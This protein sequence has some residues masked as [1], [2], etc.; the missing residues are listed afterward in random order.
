M[1]LQEKQIRETAYNLGV[2][3]KNLSEYGVDDT[4]I[5]EYRNQQEWFLKGVPVSQMTHTARLIC[6]NKQLTKQVFGKLG[7]PCPKSLL[8]SDPSHDAAAINDFWKPD[9]LYVCKPLDGMEGN[10]VVMNIRE[11]EE[12]KRIWEIQSKQYT[13]FLLEEQISGRDIRMHVIGGESVAVCVR[14]PAFVRGNGYLSVEELIEERRK[15]IQAQN[16]M[17]HLTLDDASWELLKKQD[18]TLKSIPKND[19]KVQL[20]YIANMSHGGVAT[21]ITDVIHP[22]YLRWAKPLAE[23]LN[24]STFAIDIISPDYTKSPNEVNAVVLEV[25]GEADW[26]HHTFSERRTHDIPQ[27]MINNLFGL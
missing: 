24:L 10:G 4:I 14:E 13:K 3:V 6:M 23:H 5:L 21:D 27:M 2:K 20:K 26:L 19:Q 12:L 16:P 25:N 9:T 22:E 8:F 18:L 15:V 1:H 17:N 7:I 11:K